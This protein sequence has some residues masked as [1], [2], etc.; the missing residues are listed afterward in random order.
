MQ[1]PKLLF[2]VILDIAGNIDIDASSFAKKR[3]FRK[4]GF[5]RRA[6]TSAKVL[7]PDDSRKEKQVS[8]SPRNCR[9]C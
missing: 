1:K 5:V 8:V 6:K 9:N 3:L 4:M 2:T 7:I